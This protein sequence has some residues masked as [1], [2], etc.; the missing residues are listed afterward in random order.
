M[1]GKSVSHSNRCLGNLVEVIYCFFVTIVTRGCAWWTCIIGLTEILLS[2]TWLV[3]SSMFTTSRNIQPTLLMVLFCFP[4]LWTTSTL[5]WEKERISSTKVDISEPKSNTDPPLKSPN[6]FNRR[7]LQLRSCI[8]GDF[9]DSHD[10]FDFFKF[11]LSWLMA[12]KGG[13]E[14]SWKCHWC[15]FTRLF[16]CAQNGVVVPS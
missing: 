8:S 4:F 9:D 15:V 2:M 6:S 16:C 1:D 12:E 14:R 3:Q 10:L 5:E 7:A 11:I 13:D